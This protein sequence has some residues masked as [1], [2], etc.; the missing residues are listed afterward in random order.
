MQRNLIAIATALALGASA[1]TALAK[2]EAKYSQQKSASQAGTS[3]MQPH[4]R[5]QAFQ[6]LMDAADRL[7]DAAQK[8]AQ[9]KAGDQRNI[10]IDQARKALLDTQR[11]MLALPPEAR[12]AD[13]DANA[14]ARFAQAAQRLREAIQAMADMPPG[15]GRDK[16]IENAQEALIEA[17]SAWVNVPGINSPSS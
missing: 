7:R 13:G 4:Q 1:G 15:Q 10:A 16:A 3:A 17:Q 9:L 6:E 14:G 2:D 8:T 11:A 12:R 5:S